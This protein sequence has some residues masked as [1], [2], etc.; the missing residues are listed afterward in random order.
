[1]AFH[2]EAA[3]HLCTLHGCC[4]LPRSCRM[5]N[6]AMEKLMGRFLSSRSHCVQYSKSRA[7]P[8]PSAAA[9]HGSVVKAVNQPRRMFV[10]SGRL[11]CLVS[12]PFERPVLGSSGTESPTQSGNALVAPG[13][14]AALMR[15][16]M[17]SR[18]EPRSLKAK[19]Q[20]LPAERGRLHPRTRAARHQFCPCYFP[21][22]S[23]R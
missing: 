7:C 15:A 8:S 23:T 16:N 21:S 10:R 17:F 1:M 20:A 12:V 5:S 2:C 6:R 22:L 18:R 14:G 19:C 9:A 13:V 4:P 3:K 11:P